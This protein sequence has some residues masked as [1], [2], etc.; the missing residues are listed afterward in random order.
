[1][2]RREIASKTTVDVPLMESVQ[3]LSLQNLAPGH[4][5]FRAELLRGNIFDGR[6]K[7]RWLDHL[8]CCGSI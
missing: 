2:A 6:S 8:F 1:M 7:Y 5:T 3:A 4:D